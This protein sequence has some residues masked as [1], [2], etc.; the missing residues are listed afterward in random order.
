MKYKICNIFIIDLIEGYLA[1]IQT[2]EI[3]KDFMI[4][5]KP[6]KLMS[7]AIHYFR[8]MP[9][10]WELSLY[11]L[12]AL[13]F[14]TV[15]TYV[16][17][18]LHEPKPGVFNYEGIAD[19]ASF[20]ELAQKMGLYIILR[21]TPYICA[22]WDFGGLPAWLIKDKNMRVRSQNEN[23]IKHIDLYFENFFKVVGPYQYTKGGNILMMQ[24]ENEYGSFSE[25]KTYLRK[26]VNIMRKHGVD[27][28]LFTSDGGWPEVLN[29]GALGEDGILATAN[30]GSDANT[31]FKHLK[32]YQE[33]HGLNHPL[34]CMEFWDGWFNNWGAD[35]IRRDA[36]ETA[37]ALKEVLKMGSVNLYMFHGGTNFGFFAGNSDFDS[38]NTCMIT[39]YD[40][41]APLTESGAP[42]EKFFE[43]QKVVQ[44]VCPDVETFE[45]RY[46]SLSTYET[47][48]VKEKTS[49]FSNLKHLPL[50]K[51][52]TTLPMEMLDQNFGYVVYETEMLEKRHVEKFK[53]VDASDR[54]Q[55][56]VNDKHIKTQYQTEIGENISFDLDRD[57]NN[58]KI[59]YENKSRNNYGPKVVA[60]TQNKG[61]L[62]GVMEDI[63][64]MSHFNHYSLDSEQIRSIDFNESYME[65]TPSFYKFEFDIEDPVHTYID[66]RKYGKGVILVNGF[67]IGRY[68]DIGPT[69]ALYAPKSLWKNGKNEVVV[70]ET[71]GSQI[72]SLEFSN[73][74]IYEK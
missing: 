46:P 15:E 43:M 47:Q 45:P 52:D 57:I 34:M 72:E 32:D 67:N 70:F 42:T 74:Q 9:E 55:V 68:W 20:L 54:V 23:F 69:Y 53:I 18:N 36:K 61:I 56:F 19:I 2:F 8:I 44:E 25:D 51:H 58:L 11:N 50:L 35:I 1:M 31:N 73:D 24:V 63:H 29:A 7:G 59:V 66:V 10:D 71:E 3:Q 16:P 30:F 12:K 38:V 22:E 13:G 21:P 14:N 60:H 48:S 65:N 62:G 6:T 5:G 41:D 40:Y 64:Y 4:N 33:K 28:P 37:Q 27:V 49:L 39:S 17:W 26:I